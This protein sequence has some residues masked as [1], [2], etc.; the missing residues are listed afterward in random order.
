[1]QYYIN[2]AVATGAIITRY[3][4]GTHDALITSPAA[5]TE[6]LPVSESDAMMTANTPGYT[7]VS[8]ALVAPPAPTA[9]QLLA[10]A[11]AGQIV[12]IEAAYQ[13]AIQQPLAYM[14]TSFQ[15]DKASQDLM[16][17]TIIGLQAVVAV[18]GTVPAD[19]GWWDAN[20]VKV[21]MTLLQLQGLYATGVAAVNTAFANKQAKKAAVRLASTVAAVTAITY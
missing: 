14:G 12:A 8:G 15:A 5:G 6:N 9:A 3:V 7:V 1:M 18:G 2:Y 16:A 21:L 17:Q 13:A 11:Q 19:F 20:N 10:E 4:E